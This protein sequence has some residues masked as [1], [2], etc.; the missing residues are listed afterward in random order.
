LLLT[1]DFANYWEKGRPDKVVGEMPMSRQPCPHGAMGVSI[2]G[3]ALI[4]SEEGVILSKI[5]WMV[6]WKLFHYQFCWIYLIIGVPI[7]LFFARRVKALS[8]GKA[9]LYA[10]AAGSL[11]SLLATW[12]PVVPLVGGAILESIAGHTAI[13]STLIS[14][15]IV[16]VLMGIETAL[17]DSVFFRVL[18]KGSVRVQSGALLI[19][20][21]L[22][23]IISLGLGLAWAFAHMPIFVAALDSCR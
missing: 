20:N 16:A 4:L 2:V 14:L 3:R 19:T 8:L 10:V 18:L 23:A 11:A 13:E 22:I 15:P 1:G 7:R 5:D 21:I 9:S 12:L 17:V 6:M